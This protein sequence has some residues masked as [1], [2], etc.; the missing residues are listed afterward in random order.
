[1]A[2]FITCDINTLTPEQILSALVTKT[3]AGD[4]A[5]RT[6]YVE[7]CEL[8]AINCD[9]S[10]LPTFEILKKVIGINDCGKPAIRLA[11]SQLPA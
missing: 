7:A 3:I 4:W 6:M 1:M 11:I 2:D 10:S 5:I 9:N 8:D